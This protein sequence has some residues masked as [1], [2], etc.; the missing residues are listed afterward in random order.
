MPPGR[1]QAAGRVKSAGPGD[2]PL[3]R[4]DQRRVARG[5][6]LAGV[7]PVDLKTGPAPSL[8][9]R[10]ATLFRSPAGY[11]ARPAPPLREAAVVARTRTVPRDS[12]SVIGTTRRCIPPRSR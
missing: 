8:N 1:R 10:P 7:E 2:P 12:V 5:R 11:R 6:V 4:G 9:D 3:A